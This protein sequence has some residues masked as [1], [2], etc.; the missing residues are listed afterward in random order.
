MLPGKKVLLRPFED[1]D[2]PALHRWMNDPAVRGGII[3]TWPMNQI[4]ARAW[5]EER[6]SSLSALAF[7]I[8]YME[9]STSIGVV[10]LQDI[11][12]I[13]RKAEVW[14]MLGDKTRWGQGLASEAVLLMKQYAFSSLGLEKLYL[15][16]STVN[17]AA[18]KVYRNTGFIEEGRL[19]HDMY[20]N[21]SFVDVIRMATFAKHVK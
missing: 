20:I 18:E 14:I 13:H 15:H 1:T 6:K 5:F 11:H 10:G 19:I 9:D 8:E 4:N 17:P 7:I 2:I 3:R 16:V 21:G 12:W